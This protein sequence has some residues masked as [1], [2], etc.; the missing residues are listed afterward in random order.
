MTRKF[1]PNKLS[2]EHQYLSYLYLS[3]DQNNIDNSY[4]WLQR[5]SFYLC[6]VGGIL[7]TLF[8]NLNVET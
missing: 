6:S 7:A 3:I 5:V 4:F 2:N 8:S 1:S